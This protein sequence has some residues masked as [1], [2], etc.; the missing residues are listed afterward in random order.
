MLVLT[1]RVGE[2]I[3]I[4]GGIRVTISSIKGDRVRVAISAPPH[5]K[6]NRAE[7]AARIAAEEVDTLLETACH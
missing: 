1:R 2:E 5:I 3:V 7:V 4:D 6:V